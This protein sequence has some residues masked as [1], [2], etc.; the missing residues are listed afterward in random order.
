MLILFP[1]IGLSI[2]RDKKKQRRLPPSRE[3]HREASRYL[4][5]VVTSTLQRIMVWF[6]TSADK[7][8]VFQVVLEHV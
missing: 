8:L 4:T 1:G 7:L 6:D 3:L 5:L 2:G